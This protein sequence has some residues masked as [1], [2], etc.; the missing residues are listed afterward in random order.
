MRLFRRF[1]SLQ[2][3]EHYQI[4]G[5][6]L[7]FKNIWSAPMVRSS[8]F[9][10]RQYYGE[11]VPKPFKRDKRHNRINSSPIFQ[12]CILGIMVTFFNI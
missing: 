4:H 12:K 9:A 11:P 7:G 6:R 5:E 8:Y 1:V 10:D 3:F 2:E